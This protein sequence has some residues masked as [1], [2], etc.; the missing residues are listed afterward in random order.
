M[1]LPWTWCLYAPIHYLP[2][3]LDYLEPE[4]SRKPAKTPIGFVE[5]AVSKQGLET[6]I[7]KILWLSI[8]SVIVFELL[9]FVSV[10]YFSDVWTR[11][12]L[13]LAEV[14]KKTGEGKRGVRAEPEPEKREELY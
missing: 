4:L 9:I 12:L 8:A 1:E 5:L 10:Q 13:E 6:V 3:T 7:R 11:A 14:M 2:D